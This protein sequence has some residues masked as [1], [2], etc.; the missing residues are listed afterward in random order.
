[1]RRLLGW[2]LCVLG[3]LLPH[4]LRVLYVEGLGWIAQG[5]HLLVRSLLVFILQR[6]KEQEA[7]HEA[8]R[9]QGEPDPP[10]PEGTR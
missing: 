3:L 1:M 7:A 9:S 5:F 8:R 2:L 10:P 6:V 4:R